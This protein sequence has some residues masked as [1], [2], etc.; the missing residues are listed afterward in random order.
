MPFPLQC[1]FAIKTKGRTKTMLEKITHKQNPGF[2]DDRRLD[3][4]IK[5]EVSK[6][7]NEK[8][9]IQHQKIILQ[10]LSFLTA[11]VY[12]KMVSKPLTMENKVAFFSCMSMMAVA[13]LRTNRQKKEKQIEFFGAALEKFV[14]KEVLNSEAKTLNFLTNDTYINRLRTFSNHSKNMNKIRLLTGVSLLGL[15]SAYI[16]NQ[17]TFSN[18][19]LTGAL[20]LGTSNLLS[21]MCAR[22]TL[23]KI[24]KTLPNGVNIPDLKQTHTRD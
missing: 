10:S 3:E 4:Y 18:S 12:I 17:V 13:G 16:C 14:T 8:K 22:N 9:A 1:Q 21:Y 15:T 6:S 24:K 7:P 5:E 2:I 19:L 23:T 20:I 11:L